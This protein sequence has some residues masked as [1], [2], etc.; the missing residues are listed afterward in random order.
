MSTYRG[1]SLKF[2]R[3]NELLEPSTH[4]NIFRIPYGKSVLQGG[5]RKAGCLR[6]TVNLP[7]DSY[8][9]LTVM[10]G[11]EQSPGAL[12]IDGEHDY[13]AT[14]ERVSRQGTTPDGTISAVVDW[15]LH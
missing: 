1:V 2:V 15:Q 5:V 12:C 10:L 4:I 8:L 7:P 13:N 14:L 3:L 11:T 6:A 9:Q